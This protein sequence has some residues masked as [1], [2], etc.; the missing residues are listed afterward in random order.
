MLLSTAN[1]IYLISASPYV[2]TIKNK[3]EYVNEGCILI[4]AHCSVL[5]LND[6]L[7]D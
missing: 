3:L 5:L 4:C 7:D 2:S 1:F 6:A